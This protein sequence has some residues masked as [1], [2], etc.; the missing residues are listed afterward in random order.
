MT[1]V[2]FPPPW[3]FCCKVTH[4][5]AEALVTPRQRIT[6]LGPVGD[7]ETHIKAPNVRQPRSRPERGDFFQERL[8]HVIRAEEPQDSYP[9]DF[10]PFL[11]PL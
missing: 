7:V 10:C 8:S 2:A 4:A 9:E 1:A 11:S 5:Q 6:V 3:Q